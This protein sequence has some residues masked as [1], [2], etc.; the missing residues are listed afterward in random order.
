MSQKVYWKERR[1]EHAKS[2]LEWVDQFRGLIVVLFI[3]A[4]VSWRYID[5]TATF[6]MHGWDFFSATPQ[7]ITII[8]IGQQIFLFMVGFVGALAYYKHL[9]KN[10][11][12]FPWKKFLIRLGSLIIL[13]I[14]Y[15]GLIWG[16]DE[17][18]LEAGWPGSWPG[19][20][21]VF[22]EG[23]F[24]TIFWSYAVAIPLLHW[25]QKKPDIRVFFSLAI[26]ITH[27][28]LYTLTAVRSSEIVTWNTLN[29]IGI[30]IMATCTYDWWYNLND[31]EKNPEAG[32]K[33]RVLPVAI[34]S[35]VVCYILNYVQ[36]ADH[37]DATTSLALMAI[38]TSQFVCF[39]FYSFEKVG[40]KIPFLTALG[41]NVLLMVLIVA[42]QG[43]WLGL[44]PVN[45][46]IVAL[47]WVG[48]LPIVVCTAIAWILHRYKLYL[49]F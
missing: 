4:D 27:A 16:H 28:I 24:A 6:L 37:T 23:T 11:D 38:G 26:F 40:V 22:F 30:T 25:T 3:I 48:I 43:E 1:E 46:A 31:Q 7:M 13:M 36:P 32:I 21:W 29:H 9:A 5:Y 42:V 45:N 2:R 18:I 12:K 41:R 17:W 47:L 49:R 35:Y 20:Q 34:S 10:N 39:I 15:D 44:I 14:L 19:W 8:D 33:K